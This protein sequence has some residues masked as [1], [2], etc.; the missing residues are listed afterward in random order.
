MSTNNHLS[1]Y[2]PQPGDTTT[3][4][5]NFALDENVFACLPK[6]HKVL[7]AEMH[8]Y[9]S[10]ASTARI[11]TQGTDGT[12]RSYFLKYATEDVE[13]NMM[14]GEFAATKE[15]YRTIPAA[16][17]RPLAFGKFKTGSPSTYFLLSDF[18][19]MKSNEFPD[20]HQL[21]A[22]IVHLHTTSIS[23]TRRFKFYIRIYH[24]RTP[25]ATE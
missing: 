21:C 10:W 22:H 6:G 16:V 17:P 4:N 19:D 25:Q 13:C 24:S 15:L 18:V 2:L 3:A 1:H 14:E 11:T 7:L 12:G 8:G 23:L 9:S 5:A 20:P